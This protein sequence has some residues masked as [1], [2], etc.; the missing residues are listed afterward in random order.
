[1]VKKHEKGKV[2]TTR[3][4]E[5]YEPEIINSPVFDTV[6]QE[7]SMWKAAE[8]IQS[9]LKKGGFTTPQSYFIWHYVNALQGIDNLDELK[10]FEFMRFRLFYSRSVEMKERLEKER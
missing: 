3:H 6:E 5:I 9:I 4:P 10:W 8:A 2:G 7:L 1:M